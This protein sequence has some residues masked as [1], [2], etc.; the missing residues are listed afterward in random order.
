[1]P[2]NNCSEQRKRRIKSQN[3]GTYESVGLIH[4]SLSAK[5]FRDRGYESVEWRELAQNIDSCGER[6]RSQL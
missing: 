6:L 5:D 4:V 2:K 3:P 1:M